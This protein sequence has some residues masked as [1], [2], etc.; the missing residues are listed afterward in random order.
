VTRPRTF[1]SPTFRSSF[2]RRI[3]S[4]VLCGASNNSW[5]ALENCLVRNMG[6]RLFSWNHRNAKM[7]RPRRPPARETGFLP[8]RQEAN[9][10]VCAA[11]SAYSCQKLSR[12]WAALES[13]NKHAVGFVL[14]GNLFREEDRRLKKVKTGGPACKARFRST[15]RC[16]GADGLT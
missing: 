10:A 6:T 5:L 12:R 16:R 2:W 11:R 13:R 15:R 4:T 14:A 9:L 1:L 3:L 8:P 7:T